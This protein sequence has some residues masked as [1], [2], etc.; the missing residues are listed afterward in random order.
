[1]NGLMDDIGQMAHE[2]VS[3][4]SFFLPEFKP[5]GR[6]GDATL[7]SPEA[8]LLDMPKMIG[9]LNGLTSLVKYGLSSCEGGWGIQCQERFY[10]Q[11]SAGILEYN[12][13]PKMEFAA[14]TFEG[15]SLLGG[16]DNEW[17]GRDFYAHNGVATIDPLDQQNHVLHFP[18]RDWHGDFFSPIINNTDPNGDNY[19]VKFRYLSTENLAGG[20]IGY[21]DGTRTYLNTHTNVMCDG[22]QMQSNGI[23]IS[24]QFAIPPGLESF[25]IVVSD[26][27]DPGGN[28]YFDDIQ[29]AIGTETTCEG[30]N[31]PKPNPNG[32]LGY[33]TTVV[34]KLATLLTAGRLGNTARAVVADAFNK[35]GSAD[36]G[37]RLAQELIITTA[38]FH[39]TNI[40]KATSEPRNNVNFPQP[41]GKP[42]KAVIYLMFSGGCDS[43]N[44][45]TPHTC[46][47]GLY[48][49]YLSV[50]QQVAI[51]KNQ[52]LRIPATGQVCSQFG[53]H[54]QLP[55]VKSLYD[56]GD[57]LFFANT[58]VLS[59][60]VNKDNYYVLTNTQLF[61]H[62]HMQRETKRI[63]PYE[64]TSGTGVLGRMSDVLTKQGHNVGSFSVDRFSV[65]LV[66]KPGVT[67]S[68]IIINNRGVTPVYI[69]KSKD[70]IPNLHN[71]SEEDSGIFAETWSA[72][73]MKAI[74]TND[75]LSLELASRTTNTTFPNTYL[76]NSLNTVA[77][78]MATRD[79]R[80]VDVDTFYI[81]RGGFDTHSDVEIHLNN[82]FSEINEAFQAFSSEMK[83]Q[84]IWNN[85]TLIQ[86]SDFARTLNPNGGDGT[87]HAWGGNYMMMGGAVKGGQILGEYPEDITD[88]GPWTLGRGRM[89]PTTPWEAAFRGIASW[90]GIGEDKMSEV[91]PNLHH[92]NSSYLIEVDEMF[93]DVELSSA[94]SQAPNAKTANPTSLPTG[95]SN[96]LPS[97]IPT[98]KPISAPSNLPSSKPSM[99]PS[100]K[101]SSN[102][103]LVP[104]LKPSSK[105]SN[106]PS[107]EPSSSPSN[108][109]SIQKS[110]SPSIQHSNKPSVKITV[111]PTIVCK[112][113]SVTWYGNRKGWRKDCAWVAKRPDIRCGQKGV[114]ALCSSTCGTCSEC[115]D[116][117]IKFYFEFRGSE[118]YQDCSWVAKG[119]RARCKIDGVRDACPVVCGRC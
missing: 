115:K 65:A 10:T 70:I 36:D 15:P 31:V 92:F 3:V 57:M 30:V 28:A 74:G 109:P 25:R 106:K 94:P 64:T 44:M 45:L 35:A 12:K 33:A 101:S 19:V 37:L 96:L 112:D 77:R 34:D 91:C 62:N 105:P 85:V 73:L 21:V 53:L 117:E 13:A 78:L 58:G 22:Y 95:I 98:G 97:L 40:A 49:S 11:S 83:L 99:E 104:S 20:C 68:P 7:V 38:E 2:F 26:Q 17:V 54:P 42:Y 89:I 114:S 41:S 52:L 60:P 27:R 111:A 48:E 81:E 1:M 102:P 9:L 23:W 71:I 14:E 113:S 6:V 82:L 55:I 59:Q 75:L 108:A 5:Y 93:D 69:D 103:S 87:D 18:N 86:T 16:L 107:N 79:I 90:L 47:N 116:T 43:F 56:E 118:R 66:G 61:A 24:C 51:S 80:G 29:V 100:T 67:E 50:R 32:Q 88:E 72:S 76:G 8:T 4:F 39:T 63:D 119:S 110:N 46:S 84:N